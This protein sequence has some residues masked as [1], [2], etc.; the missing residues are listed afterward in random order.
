MTT[1]KDTEGQKKLRESLLPCPFCQSE[2]RPDC[3][4]G[5][6]TKIVVCF[7][8]GGNASLVA[9]NRPRSPDNRLREVVEMAREALFESL[10]LNINWRDTTDPENLAYFSEYKAVIKQAES[11]LAAIEEE[12]KR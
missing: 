5:A 4:E 9:W 11:A 2:G 8:C 12:L 7:H 6:N 3:L 10:A 1:P